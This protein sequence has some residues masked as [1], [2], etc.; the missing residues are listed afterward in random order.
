MIIVS[1]GRLSPP[2]SHGA[3]PAQF[4][5]HPTPHCATPTPADNFCFG[6]FVRNFMRVFSEFWKLAVK[7]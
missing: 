6:H 7:R 4:S 5:R 1:Q 3:L 2:N